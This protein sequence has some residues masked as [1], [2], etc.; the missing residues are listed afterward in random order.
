MSSSSVDLSCNLDLA[1]LLIQIYVTE[2]GRSCND[3]GCRSNEECVMAED[4]C[5]Y[6]RPSTECGKYPK[7]SVKNGGGASCRTMQCP[8]GKYCKTVDG[9]PTCADTSSQ[10]DFE[11]AGVS[12]VNGHRVN[13][14]ND[15]HNVNPYGNANAPPSEHTGN[16]YYPPQQ[17]P[18][19]S[20]SGGNNLGYPPFPS[21]GY[22]QKPPTRSETDLGYPPYPTQNRQP[23]QPVYPP[24]PNNYPPYPNYNNNNRGRP[25]NSGFINMPNLSMIFIISIIFII[26]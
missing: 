6:H 9:Q 3:I 14:N 2:Y 23:V 25:Y 5:T 26:N 18:P 1:N 12:S 4:P 16:N 13:G 21:N 8:L 22:P 20:N 7:C 17:P 10:L 11:S 15:D 19:S 24:S